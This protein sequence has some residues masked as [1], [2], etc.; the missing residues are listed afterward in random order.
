MLDWLLINPALIPGTF[1]PTG[2]TEPL[3]PIVPKDKDK[4]V[5]S[6]TKKDNSKTKSYQIVFDEVDRLFHFFVVQDFYPN[7]R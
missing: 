4:V 3:P 2:G 6:P 5:G 7:T 1:I